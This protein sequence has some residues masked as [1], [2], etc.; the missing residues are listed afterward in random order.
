MADLDCSQA[1]SWQELPIELSLNLLIVEDVASDVELVTLVLEKAEIPFSYQSTDTLEGTKQLLQAHTYDAVIADYRLPQFTAYQ[2]LKI[3]QKTGR[4]IPLILVTG[5]LGEEAAVDCIKAGMTDYVLKDRLFRLPVV[6]KRSLREFAMRRQQQAA[7]KKVEQRAKTE[8]IINQIV[9]AMRGT[10]VIDEMLQTTA[11]MLQLNLNLSCCIMVQANHQGE[12]NINYVSEA[13]AAKKYFVDSKCGLYPHYQAQLKLGEIVVMSTIDD[14]VA[15]EIQQ[16]ALEGGIRSLII[17]PLLHQQIE[18]GEIVL[19]QCDRVRQWTED[20]IGLIKTIAERCAIAIHQAKL[21]R[22]IQ[23]R[24]GRE[25]TLN[26]IARAIN[27]SLDPEF[28]LQKI[29]QLTG[30]YFGVDQVVIFCIDLENEQISIRSEWRARES[31]VC[32]QGF[33]EPIGEWLDLLPGTQSQTDQVLHVPTEKEQSELSTKELALIEHGQI[34]SI[35]KTP[36]YIRDKFFGGISLHTTTKHRAFSKEEIELL[37]QIADQAAIALYNAQS[38]E[39]LEKLV[40]ERTQQLEQEKLISE[41]ANLSK[42]DFLSNMSH[43]LRTPLTGILGFSNILLQ[44]IFGP[45][46]AKQQQYIEGVASCG[47]HLLELIND[48]LDLSKVEAGKEELAVETIV[49]E[50]LCQSCLAFIREQCLQQNLELKI[51]IASDVTTWVADRRRV[52]QILVNLLSNA[53]KFTEHGS[54]TLQVKKSGNNLELSVIDTG[55]G[56]DKAEQLGLFQPFKQLDS[57]LNR[58]YEGTGL[59]LALSRKLARLHGGDITLKSQMGQGSCFTLHLPMS[60]LP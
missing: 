11:N 43:E 52:K 20:E 33:Q 48:L 53:V 15:P 45:L 24:A 40:K 13:N 17:A 42:S 18:L 54:V 41:A 27:S 55:I 44:Q 16:I 47:N 31:V 1:G 49:V 56:I 12:M 29:V 7:L 25:E 22:Q 32:I 14:T 19:L 35:L 46:N 59:G 28:I 8:A 38:Y 6:L 5:S 51:L 50:E 30:E 2:V 10:L 23:E 26:Q 58:K 9:Q 21:F 39:M 37:K 34:L 60:Q 4:E 57:G 36:I 3:L